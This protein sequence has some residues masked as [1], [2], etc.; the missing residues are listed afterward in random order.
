MAVSAIP[1]FLV[2]KQDLM[3]VELKSDL[4]TTIYYECGGSD[5][6]IKSDYYSD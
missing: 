5:V 6:V 1:N 2:E 4:I 3:R